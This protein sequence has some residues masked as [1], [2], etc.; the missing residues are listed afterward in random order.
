MYY[1]K[2][3]EWGTPHLD[4]HSETSENQRQRENPKCKKWAGETHYLQQ[5]NKTDS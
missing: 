4:K 2:R 1:Q 5:I 3:E